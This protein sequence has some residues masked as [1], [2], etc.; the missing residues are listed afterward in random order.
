MKL[1]VNVYKVALVILGIVVSIFFLGRLSNRFGSVAGV[2]RRDYQ[3]LIGTSTSSPATLNTSYTGA[4]SAS[5]TA[6]RVSGL[7]NYSLALAYTPKS[8]GSLAYI[9]VE[10]ATDPD[11]R[12][13]YPFTNLN[14]SNTK[15]DIYNVGASSTM[16]IPF[17]LGNGSYASGTVQYASFDFTG[18]ANCIKVSA[19]EYTTSTA[20]TLYSDVLIT[21]Y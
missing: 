7:P 18:V 14:P 2:T 8:Y 6:I 11:C 19:K 16:G 3:V 15:T 1:A 9:L 21:S 17:V 13:Y 12:T 4:G 5:S 20:G 10:R